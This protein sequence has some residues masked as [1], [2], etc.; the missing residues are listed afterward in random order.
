MRHTC[1]RVWRLRALLLITI[2]VWLGVIGVE[3]WLY[4]L[5][6]PLAVSSARAGERSHSPG[7]SRPVRQ[8]LA[9]PL[10]TATPISPSPSPI[11]PSPIP[12]SPSPI[13][14][15]RVHVVQS[16]EWLYSIARQ[17]NVDPNLI[18]EVN[19]LSDTDRLE[20]GQVLYIPPSPEPQTGEISHFASPTSVPPSP[21]IGLTP[22][23]SPIVVTPEP[24]P[25]PPPVWPFAPRPEAPSLP[26]PPNVVTVLLLGAE[27]TTSWRTDSIMFVMYNPDTQRAALL[28]IPRDL[29]VAVPGYGYRRINEVDYLA[30]RTNYPGGGPALLRRVFEE[31]LGLSFD[32]YV[33]VHFDGFIRIV[34]ALGGVEVVVDCPIEDIFPDPRNPEQ[35]VHMKLEPGKVRLDG[36]MALLYSRSRLSTSDFDRARRQQQVMTGLWQQARRLEILPR[37]PQL[38]RELNDAFVTDMG[39]EDVVRLARIAFSVEPQNVQA[40]VI[41]YPLVENWR[42]PEGAAVLLPAEEKLFPALVNFFEQLAQPPS[43]ARVEHASVVVENHTPYPNWAEVAASRVEWAGGSVTA[44]VEVPTADAQT[45]LLVYRERPA[46]LRELVKVLGLNEQQIE[47]RTPQPDSPDMVLVVGPDFAVCRR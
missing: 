37:I 32:H 36:T 28:S 22:T 21:E 23:S 18:A 17:Y 27:G 5:H 19:G 13:P 24:K 46:T 3:F 29:W 12:P 6:S 42:T 15:D 14:P 11:P 33:R 2:V 41:K 1:S 31:N 40:M 26:I 43:P 4:R 45:R 16:G 47:R 9:M 34:D 8:A 30:E 35:T 44:V 20:V 7:L 10:R 25:T 39:V 38:Y